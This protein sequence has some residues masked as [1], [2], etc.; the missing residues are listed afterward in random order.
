M[1]IA[2][3]IFHFNDPE[4]CDTDGVIIAKGPKNVT[5]NK[6]KE[7]GISFCI[8][9]L[10]NTVASFRYSDLSTSPISFS[11]QSSYF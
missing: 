8:F 1:K 6:K 7:K 11:P 4:T 5:K 10:L 2:E 3:F 9:N